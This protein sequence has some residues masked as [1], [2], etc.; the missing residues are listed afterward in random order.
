MT[1]KR[2]DLPQPDGP[3]I[4]RNSPCLTLRDTLSTA[5]IGPSGVS[6]RTTM[7]SATRIASVTEA[8]D[9]MTVL[10][11]F[12]GHRR[13]RG[14]GVAGLDADVHNRNGTRLDRRDGLRQRG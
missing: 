3:M 8:L 11:A 5:V 12:A 14:G 2:V 6:N 10:L 4:E 9:G 7:S 13:C 1:L